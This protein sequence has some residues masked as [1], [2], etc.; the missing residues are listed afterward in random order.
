MSVKKNNQSN[1]NDE[2]KWS[3]EVKHDENKVK[4]DENKL[5]NVALVIHM[6]ATGNKCTDRAVSVVGIKYGDIE[7]VF[8]I[9]PNCKIVSTIEPLT[10][11]SMKA[12]TNK[13]INMREISLVKNKLKQLLPPKNK[14]IVWSQ[15]SKQFMQSIL[16]EIELERYEYRS[17][18]EKFRHKNR[19]GCKHPYQYFTQDVE[20]Y[21]MCGKEKKIRTVTEQLK[22]ILDLVDSPIPSEKQSQQMRKAARKDE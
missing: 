18:A 2:L 12:L 22:A 9:K 4:H 15:S 7:T 14:C 8:Y 1:K 10:G 17:L 3:D 5:I 20:Y 16:T 11:I 19:P 21:V 13:N 6:F